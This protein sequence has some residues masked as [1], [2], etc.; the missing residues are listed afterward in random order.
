MK[1]LVLF[2]LFILSFQTMVK[3]EDSISLAIS[4]NNISQWTLEVSL[5]NPETTYGGFQMDLVLPEGLVANFD[6][7]KTTLRLMS[8]SVTANVLPDGNVRLVCYSSNKSR[9]INGK[10]GVLFSIALNSPAVL[11]VGSYSLRAK[12]VRFS[13][14]TVE[15]VLPAVALYFD[16]EGNPLYA[17]NF[18]VANKIVHVDH[19]LPGSPLP[20]FTPEVPEGYIFIEWEGET[21][22]TMPDHD[23]TY[24]ARLALVGD[25][26]LNGTVDGADVVAVYNY[27]EDSSMTNIKFVCADINGDGIVSSADVIAIYNIISGTPSAGSKA[28]REALVEYL[29]NNK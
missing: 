16:N 2:V 1:K 29:K 4:R 14:N 22:E 13:N 17:V 8:L 25:V 5:D 18:N 19:L 26:D 3:A 21:F 12:N 15:N 6:S 24:T 23:V 10:S 11:P 20:E 9:R 7:I 27:I 28:Y